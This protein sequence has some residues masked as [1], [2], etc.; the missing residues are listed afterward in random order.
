M[1][2][3]TTK[4]DTRYRLTIS[5]G[6]SLSSRARGCSSGGS[7]YRCVLSRVLTSHSLSPSWA[8][9]SSRLIASVSPLPFRH[10]THQSQQ[11]NY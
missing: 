3:V 1:C 4:D 2:N 11:P 6:K 5:L 10:K 8:T 7:Q 9:T